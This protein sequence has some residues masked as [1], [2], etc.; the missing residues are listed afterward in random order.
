MMLQVS[1]VFSYDYANYSSNMKQTSTFGNNSVTIGYTGFNDTHFKFMINAS[2]PTPA[3]DATYYG[4]LFVAVNPSSMTPGKN[5][6]DKADVFFC[7]LEILGTADVPTISERQMDMYAIP[8]SN[9]SKNYVGRISMEAENRWTVINGSNTTTKSGNMTSYASEYTS[10]YTA[11]NTTED[12][13]YTKDNF[14]VKGNM[15]F[16]FYPESE[17]PADD[18][19]GVTFGLT[20]PYSDYKQFS[21]P[22]TTPGGSG[23]SGSSANI[24][25]KAF[26]SIILLVSMI[27]L[28]S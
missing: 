1:V 4:N 15:I 23:G 5:S 8:E 12:F 25:Q 21:L 19:E 7:N 18:A 2:F 6:W 28:T 26:T 20:F 11:N 10:P 16:V 9:T 22:S 17:V 3:A 13:S 27:A 14:T 24:L